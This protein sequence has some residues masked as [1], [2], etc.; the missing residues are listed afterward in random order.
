MVKIEIPFFQY[1]VCGRERDR[2]TQFFGGMMSKKREKF[3]LSGLQ[4]DAPLAPISSLGGTSWSFH[5]ENPEEGAW[6]AYCNDF[7]KSE[8]EYFFQSNKF[9][10]FKLKDEKKVDKFFDGIQSTEDYP[11]ISR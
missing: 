7:E 9:T 3:K 1:V 6:S 11:S 4:K 10:A 5:K 2:G 8:W